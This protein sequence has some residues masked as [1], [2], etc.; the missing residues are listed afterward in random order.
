MSSV[1]EKLS[2]ETEQIVIK[3]TT[4]LSKDSDVTLSVSGT[5]MESTLEVI[6][7]VVTAIQIE[8]RVQNLIAKTKIGIFSNCMV[9]PWTSKLL[10][11]ASWF[12]HDPEPFFIFNLM[13]DRLNFQA[14]PN[15]ILALQSV[16]QYCQKM[17]L[18]TRASQP[19]A[20]AEEEVVEEAA[21]HS[22]QSYKDDLRAGAFQYVETN[23]VEGN[24]PKPYQIVFSTNPLCMT[25]KYPQLR[26]LMRASV[27]PVP[28]RRA[29]GNLSGPPGDE[30]TCSLQYWD[31]CLDCF[32]TYSEFNLSE[33]EVIHLDLPITNNRKSMAMSSVWRV[34]IDSTGDEVI[35]TPRSLVSVMRID[36]YV[37]TNLCPRVQAAFSIK[38]IRLS[39]QNHQ[40]FGECGLPPDLKRFNLDQG[41]PLEYTL[42][43]VH[44]DS[45]SL[46]ADIWS[47]SSSKKLEMSLRMKADVSAKHLDFSFMSEHYL[48][49]PC[50]L[51]ASA[52][53]E[54]SSDQSSATLSLQGKNLALRFGYFAMHAFLRSASIWKRILNR[55]NQNRQLVTVT[56]YLVCNNTQASIRFGQLGTDENLLLRPLESVMYSWRSTKSSLQLKLCVEGLGHWRWCDPY[57][58][59]EEGVLVR[60]IDHG[61][62][63]TTVAIS[64]KKSL[65][66]VHVI[67]NGLISTASLLQDHL[68]VRAVLHKNGPALAAGA[69]VSSEDNKEHHIQ[70]HRTVLGSFRSAPSFILEPGYV[71]GIKIRLLGI[72]TPWSGDIPLSLE[73]VSKRKSVLVRVPLKE[74][75][76]C[77]TVW[78]RVLTEIVAGTCARCLLIFSPMYM[79]RSL[80]P[81]P[82]NL[83]VGAASAGHRSS[84]C[85]NVEL[86]G[87]NAA[88]Q[89]RTTGPS[90]QKYTLSFQVVEDVP[91]SDPVGMS[92]GTIEQVRDRE[93]DP[94]PID[95]VLS[96]VEKFKDGCGDKPWPFVG[97]TIR[98]WTASSQPKTDVQVNFV[99]FHPL[100]NT[101]C[102]DL[103]PWCLI[104]NCLG[105]KV[106]V[107]D[108]ESSVALMETSSVLV[109]PTTLQNST[110]QIGLVDDDGKEWYGPSLHLSAHQTHWNHFLPNMDGMIPIEGEMETRVNC[111]SR[112]CHFTVK[113]SLRNGVRVLQ[114]IPSY[115]ISNLTKFP[116]NVAALSVLSTEIV[117]DSINMA[118]QVIPQSSSED[119]NI[120]AKPV[121]HWQ[122][123][124]ELNVDPNLVTGTRLLSFC[125]S[126]TG[127]GK[128]TNLDHF[129]GG[130]QAQDFRAT[131]SLPI[132][133]PDGVSNELFILTMHKRNG[134]CFV[135]VKEDDQPQFILHNKLIIDVT[136]K[137]ATENSDT[138]YLASSN[139]DHLFTSDL[140]LET[141][142]I[143]E[144]SS[145]SLTLMLSATK[146]CQTV[147]DWEVVGQDRSLWSEPINLALYHEHFVTVP[148]Y[149]DVTC[150][151]ESLGNVT[152]IYI[153]PV[154]KI[155]VS[156]KEIRSRIQAASSVPNIISLPTSPASTD[157]EVVD[158][159]MPVPSLEQT[160]GI[161]EESF[162][163]FPSEVTKNQIEVSATFIFDEFSFT[164]TDDCRGSPTNI[165][166]FLRITLDCLTV[167]L[168]PVT[169]Y[170]KPLKCLGNALPTFQLVSISIFDA[171]LDNQMYHNGLFDFPAILTAMEKTPRPKL[172]LSNT[173]LDFAMDAVKKQSLVVVEVKVD[174]NE[175]TTAVK[176]VEVRIQ[177]IKFFVE[178]RFIFKMNRVI[179]GFAQQLNIFE[180]ENSFREVTEDFLLP[181][182][183]EIFSGNLCNHMFLDSL[184]IHPLSLLVSVHASLKMFIGLDQSP[185]HF[186]EFHKEKLMTTNY[187]LG[188]N[189]ARHYISGALFRA[190]WV[191][192]SLDLIGS[193]AGFTR[194]VGEGVKD[195]ISLPYRGIF[196]G[197]W[198]FVGGLTSGSTSLVKHL[199]AG[200]L[201]SVT[202]FASSVSRNLDRLSLDDDHCKRNEMTRRHRPQGLSQGLANG[203]SGI[204]ISLLGAIS[205][206]AHHPIQ[207]WID[208]DS[209]RHVPTGVVTGV[210]RGLVG[211]V[212]KPL[213][214]AAELVAQTGQGLLHGT[215][216]CVDT[217]H[218]SYAMPEPI[219]ASV[220]SSVKYSWK[221]QGNANFQHLNILD[222]LEVTKDDER[223]TNNVPASLLLTPEAIHIILVDED[224]HES[225]YSLDE[226]TLTLSE[227]DPTR[228]TIEINK[229]LEKP[230]YRSSSGGVK[231][232]DLPQN[233]S[234]RVVQFVMESGTFCQVSEGGGSSDTSPDGQR[235][236][237]KKEQTLSVSFFASPSSITVFK[238]TFDLAA[239]ELTTGFKQLS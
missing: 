81:N 60:S 216:W 78:C 95:K 231:I 154:S 202:N 86:P 132:K 79:A 52:F 233:I 107:K 20:D 164:L 21:G 114:I 50:K 144:S 153:E 101:L 227:V 108:A 122:L 103:N 91:P 198:S 149:G 65:G 162:C 123:R 152:H 184:R 64:I 70:Q 179:E 22:E 87:R 232:C 130:S 140:A 151:I 150:N 102:V 135:V 113:A 55:G 191:V 3:F 182:E 109:P 33:H 211:V 116:I 172:S 171:Q 170:V 128:P 124:G 235:V 206:V 41:F 53:F 63:L 35:V 209:P 137:V 83:I 39:L 40:H 77:L 30:V 186:S 46:G 72:G 181:R 4:Q 11:K 100:C 111:G 26:T 80:L 45:T 148:G 12:E 19:E 136:F 175:T 226:V 1:G 34:L 75:G 69:T 82:I 195:F 190:G 193:P 27:F 212:T 18:F 96:D 49:L 118:A 43:S 105:A 165:D 230:L 57:P 93:Y 14:G 207:A 167:S 85:Y 234:D 166:E 138:D 197:P 25:W 15:H 23:H 194:M 42:A 210:A 38:D 213:G 112:V 104:V 141:L 62:H 10:A 201:T 222:V 176:A 134:Q 125:S 145:N 187:A 200:T 90:D 160:S 173:A 218:R 236:L 44:L 215:G 155:E 163:G 7:S 127:W 139:S 178:D 24:H 217:V 157:S 48:I 133:D 229:P 59:Q 221:L 223:I 68:E 58:V 239:S 199:S 61:T 224:V 192:G 228:I 94:P 54:R 31:S 28:F 56:E 189:L 169:S 36:S 129:I 219:F 29:A 220:S 147:E 180:D 2:V 51:E 214:G 120:A 158:A 142:S 88:V 13:S 185:L 115:F 84:L 238:A 66:Q 143:A 225:S 203:L 117:I 119:C 17:N 205:G 8:A 110:F 208:A 126:K 37:N 76:Q 204:G 196:N 16:H 97:G 146:K 156:A 159:A 92:W 67:V 161:M 237:S 183:V 71:Q 74:K 177:P 168:R 6:G 9:G 32:R 131:V 188:Q 174:N 98:S 99:Q 106:L 121:L 47:F 73:S 89:L 5:H